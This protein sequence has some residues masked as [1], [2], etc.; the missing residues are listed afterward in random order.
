M[1]EGGDDI[2]KKGVVRV[3]A[4]IWKRVY[5]VLAVAVVS[6]A[7]WFFEDAGRG[8]YSGFLASNAVPDPQGDGGNEWLRSDVQKM[9]ELG[10]DDLQIDSI[11]DEPLTA[12]E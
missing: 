12:D 4:R 7:L 1:K 10:V 8:G 9:L 6:A 3:K 5:S 2:N 11:Y